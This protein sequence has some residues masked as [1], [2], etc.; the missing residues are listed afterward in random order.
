VVSAWAQELANDPTG[1]AL[2]HHV[3]EFDPHAAS[4]YHFAAEPNTAE[5]HALV[6]GLHPDPIPWPSGLAPTPVSIDPPPAE[7]DP[8]PQA[9]VLIVTYTVAE[10]QALADVLTPGHP[11]TAWTSYRNGWDE[12]KKSLQQGAPSLR[13]DRAG[14]WALTQIGDISAVLVKSDLHPA[15]DGPTL[16][17]RMLWV[18]M[19]GQVQPRLVI[20][21]GTAGGIGATT[22]LGDVIVSSRVRWDATKR[23][24]DQ[25]WAH[26]AYTS[27]GTQPAHTHLP[28]A[29]QTLIPVNATTHLPPAQRTPAILTDTTTDPTSVISTGFFAFDDARDSYGLRTY[30]PD[31]KAVEMDDAALGLACTDLADPPPWISVRNASDPQM[32]AP[33]LAEE[34]T[35]AT[36]IYEKYGYWTTIGSA[37]TCWALTAGLP[38]TPF[39]S[40]QR[41]SAVKVVSRPPG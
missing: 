2:A 31:A 26:A 36:A 27:S 9:D 16:P 10:G 33:T 37:I 29:Q 28:T 40:K 7:T 32:N 15:T 20:T 30:Q 39:I 13:S 4:G 21:T 25:P 3:I 6:A 34:T 14:R 35:Q 17:L 24:E 19:I 5:A 18:Q 23:F 8:L 11:T 22:L 12:L 1:V 41:D 38:P